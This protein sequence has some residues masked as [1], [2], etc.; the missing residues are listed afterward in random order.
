MSYGSISVPFHFVRFG[1]RHSNLVRHLELL[2]AGNVGHVVL[3][4]LL[5]VRPKLPLDVPPRPVLEHG[6]VRAVREDVHHVVRPRQPLGREGVLPVPV[7]VP[8]GEVVL[9]PQ[10][11]EHGHLL[12]VVVG[13]GIVRPRRLG[14]EPDVPPVAVR[15]V[16]DELVA[17]ALLLPQTLPHGPPE[18]ARQLSQLELVQDVAVGER[19][20]LPFVSRLAFLVLQGFPLGLSVLFGHFYLRQSLVVFVVIG[21]GRDISLGGGQVLRLVGGE[22][23]HAGEDDVLEVELRPVL[24]R[25]LVL[26][27][28]APFVA[29]YFLELEAEDARQDLVARFPRASLFDDWHQP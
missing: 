5:V 9:V 25:V 15:E 12:A 10:R 28:A 27:A 24:P 7:V 21:I 13:Q 17:V 14:H 23:V 19:P 11:L 16:L 29:G 18:H 3:L 8:V 4:L 1:N 22:A 6:R 2:V 26:V 20:L